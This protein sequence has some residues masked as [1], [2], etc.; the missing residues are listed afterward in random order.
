M[1]MT[2]VHL[3][4]TEKEQELTAFQ[5]GHRTNLYFSVD[6]DQDTPHNIKM[7]ERKSHKLT[8]IATWIPFHHIE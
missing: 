6:D 3:R 1:K 2:T 5:L 8:H 4:E 7:D